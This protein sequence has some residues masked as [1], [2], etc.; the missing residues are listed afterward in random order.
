MQLTVP[1]PKWFGMR[2]KKVVSAGTGD[3]LIIQD[4]TGFI[5][6]QAGDKIL[7]QSG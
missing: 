1:R 3:A 6:Q 5:L 2:N 7:T 4:G